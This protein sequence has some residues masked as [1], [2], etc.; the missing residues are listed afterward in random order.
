MPCLPR[1]LGAILLLCPQQTHSWGFWAH[2]RI[3]Y[4]AVLTLPAAMLV[5]YKP[6]LDLL[7]ERAT[8]A[9]QR[10]YAV[11]GEAARHYIDLEHYGE[12]VP[13]RWQQAQQRY[14][15]K[16]LQQHGQ[17]PWH[18]YRMMGW[19]TK[20]FREGDLTAILHLSADLG[21]YVADAHVPLHTTANYDGQLTGQHGIHALWESRLP[22]LF[23]QH[24]DYLVGKPRYL[25]APLKAIWQVVRHAHQLAHTVLAVASALTE[26][27][28]A[29]QQYAMERRGTQVRKMPSRAYAHAYHQ[30]L[31]GMVEGQLRAAIHMVASVW[32]TCWVNAGKPDLAPLTRQHYHPPAPKGKPKAEAALPCR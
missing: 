30:A 10:R 15:S 4:H 22:E 5:L 17:L 3:N 20:A 8:K 12:G 7:T 16:A 21:H 24:Y 9:D 27:F 31:Q 25:Q 2:K 18:I 28:P 29:W 23:G 13:E 14:G 11:A 1:L 32:Y 6:Y 19:L 26:S